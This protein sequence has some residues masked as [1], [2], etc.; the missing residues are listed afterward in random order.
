LAEIGQAAEACSL[1]APVLHGFTEGFDTI[2]V[3]EGNAIL[4]ELA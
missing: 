1:L 2:D 3:T 4:Y